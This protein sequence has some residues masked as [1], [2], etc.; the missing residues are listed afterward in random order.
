MAPT[1]AKRHSVDD[2][3]RRASTDKRG[4][5]KLGTIRT[6]RSVTGTA[7]PLSSMAD[8]GISPIAVQSWGRPSVPAT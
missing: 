7:F 4:S 1:S 5:E 3:S 8:R 6:S 2:A